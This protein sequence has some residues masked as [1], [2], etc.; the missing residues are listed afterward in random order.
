MSMSLHGTVYSPYR[1]IAKYQGGNETPNLF[2]KIAGVDF[3]RPGSLAVKAR[4]SLLI[5]P[6]PCVQFV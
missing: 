2:G 1:I 4:T 3:E 5:A 6:V